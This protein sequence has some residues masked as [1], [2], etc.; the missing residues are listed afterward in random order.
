MCHGQ[1]KLDWRGLVMKHWLSRCFLIIYNR[2]W[3]S[4]I[5]YSCYLA[6]MYFAGIL[7]W[8]N[9]SFVF[10]IGVVWSFVPTYELQNRTLHVDCEHIEATQ[11]QQCWALVQQI[12]QPLTGC[13][14]ENP[15]HYLQL[16]SWEHQSFRVRGCIVCWFWSLMT[17]S[18]NKILS[19]EL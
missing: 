6:E 2:F 13:V 3:L 1:T 16:I 12:K 9:S 11:K 7:S 10:R 15:L 4:I 5:I 8:C 14:A 17:T 18:L 19:H